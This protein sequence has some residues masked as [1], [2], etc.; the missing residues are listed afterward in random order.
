MRLRAG[1]PAGSDYPA[2]RQRRGIQPARAGDPG[3]VAGAMADRPGL[4]RRTNADP[5]G[6]AHLG[7]WRW[8]DAT[9]SLT[10]TTGA[11]TCTTPGTPGTA[12]TPGSPGSPGNGTRR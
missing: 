1:E 4:D 3:A 2:I 6:P 8:T 7:Q 5:G 11:R 12:R 10:S 9:C